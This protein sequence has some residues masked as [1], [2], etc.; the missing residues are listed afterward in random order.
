MARSIEVD[1]V[2]VR[3][4]TVRRAA[5]LAVIVVV[6]ALLVL[7]AYMRLNQPPEVVARNTIEAAERKAGLAP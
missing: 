3:V 2:L 5:V 7:V 4:N 1:W 6:A